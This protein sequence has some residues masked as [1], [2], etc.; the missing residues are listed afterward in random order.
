MNVVQI[1]HID[2]TIEEVNRKMELEE[3]QSIVGGYIEQ[4]PSNTAHRSLI[5]NEEGALHNLPNNIEAT[6]FKKPETLTLNGY[7]QGTVLLVKS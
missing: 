7:L 2:G 4:I 6:K 5:V 1:I 3:M